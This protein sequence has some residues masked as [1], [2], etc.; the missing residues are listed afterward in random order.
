MPVSRVICLQ[1]N[2]VTGFLDVLH[3][4]TDFPT[5]VL[6]DAEYALHAGHGFRSVHDCNDAEQEGSLRWNCKTD[7]RANYVEGS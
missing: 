2:P 6:A 7:L 4:L 1:A 5:R 3:T